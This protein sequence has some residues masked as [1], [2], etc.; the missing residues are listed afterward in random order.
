MPTSPGSTMDR[1]P[2]H[3]IPV[4]WLPIR[5]SRLAHVPYRRNQWY[6]SSLPLAFRFQ[7]D[8]RCVRVNQYIIANLGFSLNFGGIDLQRITFPATMSIDY[9]RVYQPQNAINIGC[10]PKDFPTAAYIQTSVALPLSLLLSWLGMQIPGGVHEPELDNLEGLWP[11]GT[12]ESF[13]TNL[14]IVR[15]ILRSF[16]ILSI[17][18]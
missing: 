16:S 1:K 4:P 12:E 8:I 6:V 3:S 9:I 18:N 5:E 13:A 7:I 11:T 2:G 10:D 14:L 17:I 15:D